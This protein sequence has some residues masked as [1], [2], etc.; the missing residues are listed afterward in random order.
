[1]GA[2]TQTPGVLKFENLPLEAEMCVF[3]WF[4][5][6]FQGLLAPDGP[7]LGSM[8]APRGPILAPSWAPKTPNLAPRRRHGSKTPAPGA[9]KFENLPVEAE[10]CVFLWFSHSFQGP[11]LGA[12]IQTRKI[13]RTPTIRTYVDTSVL[14]CIYMHRLKW[15]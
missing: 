15:S 2:K 7:H 8:L 11:G 4:S 3:F 6:S 12:G 10:M 13:P 14:L 1:M 5:Y 9:L